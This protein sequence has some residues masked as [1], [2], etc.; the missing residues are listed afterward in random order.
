MLSRIEGSFEQLKRF[1]SDASHELRTPLAAICSVGE[2]GRHKNTSGEEYR[3]MIG[4]MLEEVNRLTNLV[5]SLLTLSRA[6]EGQL[7]LRYTVFP[8][9]VWCAMPPVCWKC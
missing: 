9:M 4:S 1:T 5:E 7:P 3:D 2:V 6:D 8:T